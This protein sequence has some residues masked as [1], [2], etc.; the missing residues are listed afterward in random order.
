[1]TG[2]VLWTTGLPASGKSTLARAAQ[3]RLLAAG[4]C[5]VLLDGDE[6]R[7][8]LVP[9][10][11]YDP[12]ARR[13]FYLSLGR[14][15]ALLARQGVVVLVAATAH[16]RE[17]RD[18]ARAIAPRFAEVF[19]DVPAEVCRARDAKGLY[20][21]AE[22]GRAPEL[23][24]AGVAYEPPESPTIVARGG[25]DVIALVALLEWLELSEPGREP[26]RKP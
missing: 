14:M 16:R 11:G 6:V 24:G 3:S 8:A 9:R 4:R 1:M 20:A 13:D 5:A 12:V 23:P 17:Y 7:A 2:A 10:P 15:A 25:E 22:A 19:V 21:R 18:A 26:G